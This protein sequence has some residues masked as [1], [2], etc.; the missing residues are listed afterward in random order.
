METLNYSEFKKLS[1]LCKFYVENLRKT[2]LKMVIT[3]GW[4]GQAWKPQATGTLVLH[5][6]QNALNVFDSS[7][8]YLSTGMVL[9]HCM[10]KK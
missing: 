9:R 3:K 4:T 6:K 2:N 1:V 8:Y 5:V 7:Q 10:C